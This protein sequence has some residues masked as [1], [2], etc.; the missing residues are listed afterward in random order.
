AAYKMVTIV[1]IDGRVLN[2]IVAEE[3]ETRV[4]LKTVEQPRVIIAKEDID[5]RK[6]STKSMMPDGQ[7][8][9]MKPQELI[10]LI[11]Y[12]RTTAQVEIA[13]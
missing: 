10:D 1:T 5:A 6:T 8:D 4:V 12:L 11:K 7:F 9:K 2:G 3:D 13:Q